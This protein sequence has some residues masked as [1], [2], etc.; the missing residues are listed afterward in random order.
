MGWL[1]HVAAALLLIVLAWAFRPRRGDAAACG[2]EAESGEPAGPG[3]AVVLN[4]E[5]MNCSHCQESVQRALVEQPGVRRVTVSLDEGRA[6]VEGEGLDPRV[7]AA[8]VN[9]LGY[10]AEPA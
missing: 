4:V 1:S 2:C 6:V 3:C 7:L 10:V 5:G 9:E 8:V